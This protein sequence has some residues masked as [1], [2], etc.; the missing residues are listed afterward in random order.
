VLAL[1]EAASL[2]AAIRRGWAAQWFRAWAWQLGNAR[3]LAARRRFVQSR[4]TVPDRDLLVGG[5][6]PLAPGFLT[7]RTDEL[8]LRWFAGAV[9]GYW[10]LARRWVG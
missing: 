3:S 5:E 7:S 8:L 10:S 6:P 2:V 9:N 4:R 1:Y